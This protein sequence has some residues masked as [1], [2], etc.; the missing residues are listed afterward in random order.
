M[1]HLSLLMLILATSL[2]LRADHITGGEMYYTLLSK[3]GGSSTYRVTL[4]QFRSCGTPGRNFY[5]PIYIGVFRRGNNEKFQELNV[6]LTYE[7]QISHT[8]TDPCITRP[9]L[10]CY[11]VGYWDFNVT[12]PDS[13]DG[14]IITSQVTFRVDAINNLMQ[15]YGRIGATY[16][17]E[18]PGNAQ[19]ATG[20]TNSSARFTGTDL[21]TV[22]ANNSFTYSFAA[23]DTDGDALR[24]YFCE[25]WQTVGYSGGGPG[26]GGPGGG[27]NQSQ[28]P[29]A[30]PYESVPYGFGFSESAPLGSRVS[31]DPV[32]GLITGV[33]PDVGIYVVTVCVQE[34]R[35]G[36]AIAT[37]RKDLQINITGC[38]IAAATLLP[39]YMLCG[40]SQQL[41]VANQST[42]PLI[43]RWNWEFRNAAGQLV[44]ESASQTADFTFPLPGTYT[45]KLATNRGL[46]CPDSTEATAL[47][48]PGFNPA[49][50][51]TGSCI[52]NPVIFN[53]QTTTRFG[54]VNFW[55]WD[56]GVTSS[57]TDHSS[58]QDTQWS[59][60]ARGRYTV[61]LI[62]HNSVGCKDTLQQPVDILDKPPILLSFRDTLICPPDP[63]TLQ[64]SGTGI[65]TWSP[66]VNMT[67]AQT[68]TPRVNV[69]ADTKYYVDLDQNGCLNRDSVMIRTTSHVALQMPADTL[70]CL[71]DTIRLQP[72]SNALRYSWTPATGLQ[73]PTAAAPLVTPP[74][75]TRYF[76]TASISACTASGDIWVR[77]VPYPV[78]R[79]GND[80]II[81]FGSPAQLH[82]LTDGSAFTWTPALPAVLNPLIRPA[83]STAYIFTATDNRGC[84]KPS[85]DT[86]L[87]TVLPKVQAFAGRD[88][89]VVTGQPLHLQASGGSSYL[90]SPAEGISDTRIPNP[91]AVFSSPGS[92]FRLKVLVQD[93]AGCADS[94]FMLVK[95]YNTLPQVFVPT[96]FTP[97]GDGIN[98]W[99]RPIGAG[100]SEIRFFRVYNRW[101]QL[102]YSGKENNRGWDGRINGEL[103]GNGV[104]VWQVSAVDFL[105][106]DFFLSGTATLLR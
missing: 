4:K 3:S 100:I 58:D 41:V 40:N 84:P 104:F 24:Y 87:V 76:L 8:S 56:F 86:V 63:L 31:I 14:Y 67:G 51:S 18:I 78:A 9:P 68:P 11:F 105:G 80:T 17:A 103:Q 73:T 36:I 32:T 94:A 65:F 15:G 57:Q 34:I 88:T 25:A 69:T 85:R 91:I 77:T 90:W 81:C 7:E 98:D 54:T 70:I 2:G 28:P 106:A 64:A 93:Q 83:S 55:N 29:V 30:P 71:G 52:A 13:P 39:E 99:L 43:A 49:F 96:A 102:V 48:Y 42:S 21:V 19:H 46:Q 35:N 74:G 22:C 5:N 44:Y 95:V 79:A 66:A 53:D 12:V 62:T 72:Q 26:G 75:D 45:V 59:Y 92:G 60:P 97:N 61:T 89:A 27:G 10:V 101:G 6:P 16:T 23:N 1:K 38:T 33:A 50:S 82:A 37:Q 20:P 47:V